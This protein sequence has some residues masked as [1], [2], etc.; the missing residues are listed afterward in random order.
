MDNAVL[1]AVITAGLSLIGTVITVLAANRST[2]AALS[3]QSKVADQKIQGQIDVIQTEIAA[4]NAKVEK[5]NQVIDRTY[6]LEAR[7]AVVE[8]RLNGKAG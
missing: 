4:L 7:V 1:V 2:L 8:D 6:K 5:H 3:E